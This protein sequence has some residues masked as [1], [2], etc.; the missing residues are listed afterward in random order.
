MLCYVLCMTLCAVLPL[1]A[2]RGV[3]RL[4]CCAVC[5]RYA[6]MCMC[7]VPSCTC[8]YRGDVNYSDAVMHCSEMIGHLSFMLEHEFT[9]MAVLDEPCTADCGP[10]CKAH[11]KTRSA[12]LVD[13][14]KEAYTLP[15]LDND[16]TVHVGGECLRDTVPLQTMVRFLSHAFLNETDIDMAVLLVLELSGLEKNICVLRAGTFSGLIQP[17]V[18][19]EHTGPAGT[20]TQ[21]MMRQAFGDYPAF[22]AAP[23][24]KVL[25]VPVSLR[26]ERTGPSWHWTVAFYMIPDASESGLATAATMSYGDSYGNMQAKQDRRPRSDPTHQ[27]AIRLKPGPGFESWL[28]HLPADTRARR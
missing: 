21:G 11:N 5:L 20:F 6:K 24:G 1:C 16:N 19:A 15:Y 9:L 7:Y 13:A 10:F 18:A 22:A 23:A 4:L 3:L 17:P 2:V 25:A 27:S 8:R 28:V 14:L 26:H 12:Q